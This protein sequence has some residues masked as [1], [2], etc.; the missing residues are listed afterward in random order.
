MGSSLLEEKK[1]IDTK[2][3]SVVVQGPI[4][5]E[6]TPQC[7]NSIRKYLPNAEIILSTWEGSDIEGL[8]YDVLV[9][10]KDPGAKLVTWPHV[11]TNN[12]NRQLVSIQ[13]GLKKV[14]RKYS[15]KLR[16]DLVLLNDNIL[17]FWDRFPVMDSEYKLFDHRMLVCSVFSMTT[18]G[19][20]KFP[21]PF[22]PADFYFFGLTK[23]LK[24]YFLNVPLMTD[25]E[26]CNYK[27]KF[28]YPDRIPF[29]GR[30]SRYSPE[31]HFCL[32][33]VKQKFQNVKYEDVTDWN[34]ENFELS[35]N[36][37]YS[38][39]IFLG[40][41]Q[42]GIFS[43]KYNTEMKLEDR[44]DEG[45]ISYMKFQEYYKLNFDKNYEIEDYS[46]QEDRIKEQIK[47]IEQLAMDIA[48]KTGN[49][50]LLSFISN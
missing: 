41:K 19:P 28:L 14:E 49:S 35:N 43:K 38:N 8:D 40:P 2:E 16:S 15:F 3:I 20:R 46:S 45:V 25:D 12:T 9:L 47:N 34:E 22:H 30:G 13:G 26:L 29:V 18:A 17:K 23:D 44:L 7:L 6:I 37:L 42:S 21:M 4:D 31:Q 36:I 1:L 48:R 10:N 39:F 50:D 5:S 27:T 33:C 11:I 24:A 32:T